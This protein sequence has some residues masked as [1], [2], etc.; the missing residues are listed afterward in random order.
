MRAFAAG[1]RIQLLWALIDGER[2][3]EEL[4]AATGLSQSLVSQQL[5]VLRD[6]RFVTVRRAGRHGYYR[7][8]D[9]HIPELLAAV[10]HH[11]EHVDGIPDPAVRAV[12]E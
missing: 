2:T 6:L 1:S 12:A 4:E 7:L 5:R 9:H 8:H 10:R 3:V 11:R